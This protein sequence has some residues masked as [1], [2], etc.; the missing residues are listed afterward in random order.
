MAE[1]YDNDG[2]A[3]GDGHQHA[4]GDGVGLEWVHDALIVAINPPLIGLEDN[5]GYDGG[6][7][8]CR[9]NTNTHKTI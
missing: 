7:C 9:G 1:T 8:S 6:K 4:E 2:A 3:D 5:V